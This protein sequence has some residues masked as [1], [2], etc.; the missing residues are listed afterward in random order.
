MAAIA[1][2]PGIPATNEATD[3][4]L[5]RFIISLFAVLEISSLD[6]P[7]SIGPKLIISWIFAPVPANCSAKNLSLLTFT[8]GIFIDVVIISSKEILFDSCLVLFVFSILFTL[9]FD[10]II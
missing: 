5:V 9:R 3:D 1:R 10:Y 4:W 8:P 2:P 6:I 7:A